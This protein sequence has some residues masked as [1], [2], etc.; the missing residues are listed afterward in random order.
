MYFPSSSIVSSQDDAGV[1]SG[2]SG[3]TETMDSLPSS[4]FISSNSWMSYD[5]ACRFMGFG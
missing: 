1:R 5:G 2:L 3:V 4:G